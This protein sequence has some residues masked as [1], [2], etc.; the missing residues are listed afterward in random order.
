MSQ[1][2]TEKLVRRLKSIHSLNAEDEVALHALPIRIQDIGARQDVVREGDRPSRSCILFEGMSAWYKTTGEGSRQILSFQIPGDMPDLHSL[3]LDVMDSSLL[4][5]SPCKFGFV[6]HEA[7]RDLCER[8]PKVASAFWRMTLI[9]G[10][11]FREWVT[12][13]SARKAKARVAH[14]LCEHVTRVSAVG[15][16]HSSVRCALPLTQSDIADATGTSTVHVNRAMQDLR[17]S[18]LIRF[19]KFE[20][21]VLDW[22]GLQDA[23]DFDPT[24]LYLVRANREPTAAVPGL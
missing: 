19:Q 16:S 20:L 15:D 22:E 4:T 17:K 12:N 14:L 24:Y 5:I 8:R 11:I 2:Y 1:P 21:E 10:A 13:N 3:H 23:G 9:D 6:E 18:K 7:I